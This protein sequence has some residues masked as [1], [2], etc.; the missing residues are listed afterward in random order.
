MFMIKKY[1]SRWNRVYP[2][3][4]QIFHISGISSNFLL[5]IVRS[6]FCSVSSW[7]GGNSFTKLII[8]YSI[9]AKGFLSRGEERNIQALRFGRWKEVFEI[10]FVV[11]INHGSEYFQWLIQK[12]TGISISLQK[13]E[14]KFSIQI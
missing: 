8:S 3:S 11:K 7:G 13:S 2:K 9:C 14:R 4:T 10:W 1:V 5:G 12:N 6:V